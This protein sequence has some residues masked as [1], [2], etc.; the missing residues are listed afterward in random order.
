MSLLQIETMPQVLPAEFSERRARARKLLG[1]D[2][3][4]LFAA[5]LALRNNDVEFDYRQDSDFFYLSGFEE[6]EAA[7]VLKQDQVVLFVRPK[8]RERE[9][10]E[11][12]RAGVEGAVAVFGADVA[13]P[14]G[15]LTERLADLLENT[16]RLHT[17]FGA[18]PLIDSRLAVAM[19]VVR[20]RRRKRVDAP[21]ELV[22]ARA[23]VHEL[24]LRKTEKELEA[25]RRA[26]AITASGHRRAMEVCRPGMNEFELQ[27]AVEGE[28]RTQG[29][30]RLAYSTI[31]G[32]G[33]NGTILHYRENDQP[34]VDGQLVL[35]DAGA[36]FEYYAADV[37]RTF[38]VNGKFSAIQKR[39]YELV[40]RS[41]EAAIDATVVGSTLDSIHD[42]AL[43]ILADG[44]VELGLVSADSTD[45]K[46]EAVRYYMHRTS[47]YLGMD[48]HD[49]GPYHRGGKP[50][51][52]DVGMVITVE[53][54]LY[55][56]LDDEDAPVALRGLGIRIEDDVVVTT[57]V[58]EV[59]TAAAPKSVPEIESAC[60]PFGASA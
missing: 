31:V 23:I 19:G 24:R 34:L 14:I 45:R 25:M 40:L 20:S 56:P 17:F 42:A 52:L 33:D 18:E 39:A 1:D 37:T 30:R 43:S 2:V 58:P 35:I 8:N 38:P 41:Q 36:E 5:P 10:W 28:F 44:F 13:H 59:L 53:P 57:G 27:N 46:K 54:G 32:G 55:V 4:V 9:T 6:P 48:V 22:D 12:R 3:L 29:S 7:L 60:L 11:G 15:E 26:A 21:T 50:L 49:V 51:P 47:H 16:R